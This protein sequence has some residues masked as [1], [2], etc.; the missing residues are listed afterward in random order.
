VRALLL[1]LA[2]A[3]P[4]ST[5]KRVTH[6]DP[7]LHLAQ[8]SKLEPLRA[9]SRD[10]LFRRDFFFGAR[11]PFNAAFAGREKIVCVKGIIT[12]VLP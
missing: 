11:E 12:G 6:V 8:D 2:P 10:Y 1:G 9:Q 5:G 3:L 7:H 4:P